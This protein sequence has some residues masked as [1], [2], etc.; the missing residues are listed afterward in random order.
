VAKDVRYIRGAGGKFQGSTG[1]GGN[2]ALTGASRAGGIAGIKARAR[3]RIAQRKMRDLAETD[4]QA[5][6]LL[7]KSPN[8]PTSWFHRVGLATNF[9]RQ[10]LASAIKR[11]RAE[12]ARIESGAP[13]AKRT[14]GDKLRDA[15][16]RLAKQ[17]KLAQVKRSQV[18]AALMSGKASTAFKPMQLAERR[19]ERAKRLVERLKA[20]VK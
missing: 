2:F 8:S 18:N 12:V 10:R 11:R 16:A 9:D 15:Q 17:S 6:N 14:L 3:L 5:K 4:R 19:A 13:T 20:R 7:A 1:G